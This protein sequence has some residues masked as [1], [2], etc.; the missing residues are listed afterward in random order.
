MASGENTLEAG[1]DKSVLFLSKYAEQLLVD[2]SAE[3]AVR[4]RIRTYE[5]LRAMDLRNSENYLR[6]AR[7]F[8]PDRDQ[9]NRFRSYTKQADSRIAATEKKSER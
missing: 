4:H 2:C 5:A 9:M 8:T 1:R 3:D 7:G 6:Q